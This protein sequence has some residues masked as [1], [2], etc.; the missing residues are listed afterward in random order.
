MKLFG[1][2]M[3]QRLVAVTTDQVVSE[4]PLP[5]GCTLNDIWMRMSLVGAEDASILTAQPYGIA[6]FVIPVPD[7]DTPVGLE[8]FWDRLVP[9][10]QAL[11][12]GVFDIDTLGSDSDSEYEL[13]QPEWTAVFGNVGNRPLE[14]FRRRRL[15]TFPDAPLGHLAGTPDTYVPTD[16]FSTHIKKDVT[17]GEHSHIL[18]GVSSPATT[19]TTSTLGSTLTDIEQYIMTFLEIALEDAY[20]HLLGLVEAGAETPY[21]ESAT[22]LAELLE[23]PPH[24]ITAGAFVPATWNV[25]SQFTYGVTVPGRFSMGA[26]TSE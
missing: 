1:R 4:F 12:A 3:S 7:P 26:L 22:F 2:R 13:G 6:G 17:A 19:T 10:D 24:E 9:K 18:F 25:F 5:K 14:I 8:L 20:K 15:I 21:V 11:A 16:L 23:A